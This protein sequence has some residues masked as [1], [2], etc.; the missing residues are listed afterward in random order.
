MQVAWLRYLVD[1]LE[2]SGWQKGKGSFVLAQLKASPAKVYDHHV[3]VRAQIELFRNRMAQLRQSDD[4]IGVQ[5]AY[6]K[7]LVIER[8][9]KRLL[10]DYSE[11]LWKPLENLSVG[12]LLVWSRR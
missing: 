3:R 5:D 4:P 9:V 1:A 12:T 10:V 8:C 11:A 6:M 2:A 7:D